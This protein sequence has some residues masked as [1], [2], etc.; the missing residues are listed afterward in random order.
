MLEVLRS[1][2]KLKYLNLS[3]NNLVSQSA[4]QTDTQ[5]KYGN[6]LETIA[7][8]G[9][10]NAAT[11]SPTTNKRLTHSS[12]NVRAKSFVNGFQSSTLLFTTSLK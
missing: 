12:H 8:E 4:T 10:G 5:M 3:Y 2:K 7:E 9:A 11:Y 1:N 6:M